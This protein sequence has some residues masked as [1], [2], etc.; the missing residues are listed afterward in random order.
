MSVD[1]IE[2]NFPKYCTIIKKKHKK[3]YIF[4]KK[5]YDFLKFYIQILIFRILV[6]V[7]KFHNVYD[8]TSAACEGN[9]TVSWV[10]DVT[11]D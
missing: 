8:Y 3:Y 7:V 2:T 5:K 4:T 1:F 10:P 11:Q 6:V 9:W